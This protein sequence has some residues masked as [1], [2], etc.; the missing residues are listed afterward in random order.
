MIVDE[1]I[2][3]RSSPM[4]RSFLVSVDGAPLPPASVPEDDFAAAFAHEIETRPNDNAHEIETRPN[5]N[6]RGSSH[7]GRRARRC[8]TA[9]R[10]LHREF[11]APTIARAEAIGRLATQARERLDKLPPDKGGPRNLLTQGRAPEWRLIVDCFRIIVN[12][13]GEERARKTSKT[14][15]GPFADFAAAMLTYALGDGAPDSLGN[16]LD[17][18]PLLKDELARRCSAGPVHFLFVD[19]ITR[20]DPKGTPRRRR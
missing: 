9:E 12:C 18:L 6:R 15:S 14:A 7:Q 13:F 1:G 5:D 20:D 3:R 16:A 11:M 2:K 19:Q 17:V 4:M 10:S 8:V